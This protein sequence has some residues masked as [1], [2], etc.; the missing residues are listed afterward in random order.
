M[1]KLTRKQKQFNKKLKAAG[2][3]TQQNI[4]KKLIARWGKMQWKIT[5]NQIRALEEA[6]LAVEFDDSKKKDKDKWKREASVSFPLYKGISC[7]DVAF[8]IWQWRSFVKKKNVLYIGGVAFGGYKQFQLVGVDVSKVQ[9]SGGV[10]VSCDIE[11][12]FTAAKKSFSIKK[13]KRIRKTPSK[14]SKKSKKK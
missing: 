10:I 11:L 1:A 7:D 8:E 4:D 9:V 13:Y 2:I 12:T 14:K 5:Q 6:S 3:D